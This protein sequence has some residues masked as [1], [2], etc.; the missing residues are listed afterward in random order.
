MKYAI[1]SLVVI[2]VALM[3]C[4][5]SPENPNYFNISTAE[6]HCVDHIGCLH[7]A[8][9]KYD[10]RYGW[11]SYTKE[12]QDAVNNYRSRLWWNP[13]D[14]DVNSLYIDR[15]PGIGAPFVKSTDPLT[16]GFWTGGWGGY[17]EFYASMA[18]WY[19]EDTIPNELKQFY[20]F[21]YI[22]TTAKAAR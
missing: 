6:I 7:E 18:E 4:A 17:T 11:I 3:L 19:G 15:F 16:L 9:H 5:N 2:F 20:N 13:A 21:D 12:Y 22:E 8:A 10:Q 14:R 1:T